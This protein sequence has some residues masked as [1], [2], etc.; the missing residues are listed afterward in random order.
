M[1]VKCSIRPTLATAA[2][3]TVYAL[4]PL[5]MDFCRIL[6]W[7]S[8]AL[9]VLAG[10]PNLR[11]KYASIPK[12]G[13]EPSRQD[14]LGDSDI[15]VAGISPLARSRWHNREDQRYLV[16]EHLWRELSVCGGTGEGEEGM[17]LPFQTTKESWK[18]NSQRSW[19]VSPGVW[20]KTWGVWRGETVSSLLLWSH[21][22]V[23]LVIS[24]TFRVWWGKA[25]SP[26]SDENPKEGT[27]LGH[28][29]RDTKRTLRK[30]DLNRWRWTV[31]NHGAGVQLISLGDSYPL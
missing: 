4:T 1:K 8:F 12:G 21:G 10:T 5:F 16:G 17:H 24:C 20:R 13:I 29:V 27:R 9:G 3:L 22:I 11:T 19:H 15:C 26:Q 6:K 2:T 7:D 25:V 28:F 18:I 30:G 23:S 31:R 14:I